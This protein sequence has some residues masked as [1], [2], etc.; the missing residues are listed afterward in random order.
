MAGLILVQGAWAG[1][2]LTGLAGALNL[3]RQVGTELLTLVAMATIA[4]AAFGVRRMAWPLPVAILGFLGIGVQIG[5]G[6]TDQLQIHLPLGITLFGTYLG[7][8][9][10]IKTPK[11][12]TT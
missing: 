4:T 5:M 3:H 11:K 8:A 6:Y 10:L 12:E 9:L 1:S 2:H 7:M